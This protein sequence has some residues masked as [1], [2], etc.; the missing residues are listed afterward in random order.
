[1]RKDIGYRPASLIRRG[2]QPSIIQRM[3]QNRNTMW[4]FGENYKKLF[5]LAR[6]AFI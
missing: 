5:Y 4:G 6:V 1:M 3:G 2:A